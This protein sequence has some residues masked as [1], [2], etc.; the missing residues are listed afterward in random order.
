MAEKTYID[1]NSGDEIVISGIAGRFPDSNNMNQ[2][3]ENLFNK[4]DLVRADHR[5]W[6]IEHPDLPERM[7]TVNN[8]EKFDADFFNISIEQAHAL[9]PMARLLLEHAYEAIVDAGINPMQLRGKKTAVIVG[10]TVLESQE[11]FMYENLQ[12]DGL[13]IIGCSK[14]TIANILSNCLDLK[15]PSY[16]VDTACSSSL[17]AI[18]LGYREIISGRCEDAIIGTAHLCLH[19]VINLNF[20]HLGILSSDGTCRPFDTDGSGYSRSETV[21]VIYLQR[22][23][24]AKRIYATCKHIKINNDGYKEE[25]ITFPSTHMQSILMTELYKECGI[26]PSFLDYMEAHGTGTKVGDLEEVNAI[27]NVLCKDRKI[28]LMI[29]S[30]KSNL[31]HA[32]PASGFTQIAK[33]KQV[34]R[35][36][37]NVF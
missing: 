18:A 10:M 31:G 12:I 22:A 26:S 5:R 23:K 33:V 27:H 36:H 37:Y 24:N 32:E 16:T 21:S 20:S 13:G 35:T 14:S 28:P 11:K 4:V 1:I 8:V 30:V 7:G 2:L 29:G 15:G 17:H 3:G 9:D 6:D 34:T 25:G 19:P